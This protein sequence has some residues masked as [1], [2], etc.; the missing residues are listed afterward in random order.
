MVRWRRVNLMEDPARLGQFDLVICRNILGHLLEEARARV[1][2]NLE[3]T[4]KPGGWLVLGAS[5]AAPGLVAAPDRPGFFGRS[6]A[7]AAA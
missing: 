7:R 6:G 3:Q 5:E 1:L 2:A 4:L